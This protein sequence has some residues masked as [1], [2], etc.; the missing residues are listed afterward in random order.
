MK[1]NIEKIT[2]NGAFYEMFESVFNE[3]FFTVLANMRPEARIKKL[4][5]MPKEYKPTEEEQELLTQ[6][7]IKLGAIMRK[8]TSRIAYIGSKLY[9]K[10][11]NGSYSDYMSFLAECDAADFLD[12]E[13][14]KKIW[15][16]VNSDQKL[17]E[18][19]KNA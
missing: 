2:I 7:N 15:D 19:V 8:Y 4:S 17:P 13:I 10:E 18:S 12:P 16:K 9:K 14:M 3:D 1:I 6:H 5:A 11:Y